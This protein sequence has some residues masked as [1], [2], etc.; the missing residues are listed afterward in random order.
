MAG[1]L[2]PQ[3]QW[4]ATGFVSPQG[5]AVLA[6][7]QGDVSAAFQNQLSYNLNTP[8]GQLASSEAAV[9]SNN[10]ANFVLYTQ[11]LDPNY[12][13]G[14]FQ[15]ALA[16]IYFL[17]RNPALPT[18]LQVAC[19][20]QQG[21][22]I[23]LNALIKDV[24]NNIYACTQAGTIP[25]AGTITLAFACTVPG[26]VAVPG[27]DD[28]SIYQT[29]PQ[30]DSV[31]VVSGVL[32]VNVETR[33][34]FEQRRRDT[35]AGNSFGP[36]GAIIGA[37]AVVPGVIDYFGFSNNTS[38]PVTVG[39]VTIAANAIYICVAGGAAAAVGLA[40]LSKKGPGAPMTGNTSVTVY[41]SNP[42]YAA[43]IPYI[44]LF[45]IPSPLQILFSVT[46]FNSPLVPSNATALI[47][48]A[49]IA[50]FA[51]TSLSANFT[52][53]ISGTVL[54][55]SSLA[56]GTIN[57]GQ[58]LSD[59]T[60]AVTLGTVI[61]GL[62][63]GSGGLGTYTISQSQSVASEEMMSAPPQTNLPLPPRARIASTLL[64]FQYVLAVA[65]L[66]PWAQ[67]QNIGIGSANATD[68]V[69]VGNIAGTTLTVVSTTSGSVAIGANLTDP[70]GLIATGT[71]I[72]AGSGSTWTVS[73]S[74]TVAG[75][76]FTGNGSGTNLTASAVTGEIGIGDVISGTGVTPGTTIISQTSG[77]PGGAGVYVTSA[78]TT[79]SGAAITANSVISCSSADHTSVVVQANQIP[80][81]TA[82]NILVGVT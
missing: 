57:I 40:I 15:D 36:A 1:T 20:G 7:V 77:T 35:V 17:T 72:T 70:L 71:Y 18:V 46:I 13:F 59:E 3:P 31:N 23:P 52:G 30:W 34:A 5:P 4:T 26:P 68:A 32:G 41:D 74:Q 56:S 55:V 14:R 27:A 78:S 62:L 63:T 33:N 2:V 79:S 16:A 76:T 25:L 80:Q 24:S 65:A 21:V 37:V 54:T 11:L 73:T 28:V 58:V 75:A 22:E 82:G 51:G 61:T 64:A 38:D 49:L 67:V 6:G 12:S 19:N 44:V 66:G 53:S 81:L 10:Y 50:A 43:P 60:G 9:I 45:E 29:I 47:Q 48:A 39:G 69:I 8:Q 42:L